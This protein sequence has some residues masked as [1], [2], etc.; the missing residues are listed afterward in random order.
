M[1]YRLVDGLGSRHPRA[2]L[3]AH[4]ECE[5]NVLDQ[6]DYIGS[7]SGLLRFV[8][9]SPGSEFIVA[10]EAGIIH[11][12]EKSCPGKVFIPAPPEE[13]C[14]C[15]HCPY[16]KLN[17]MEKLYLCMKRRSPEITL[18]QDIIRRAEEPIRRM[19]ALM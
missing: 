10:T 18:D 19:L 13:N 8:G 17:T 6:A 1:R 12:M 7:T 4:P 11:Q 5:E 15:N 9:E 3:I 2:L 14:E 16:M